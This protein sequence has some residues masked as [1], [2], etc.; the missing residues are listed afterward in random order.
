MRGGER[1]DENRIAILRY[2]E[3][4]EEASQPGHEK[5]Y[6][7]NNANVLLRIKLVINVSKSTD[8][9]CGRNVSLQ[10][11]CQNCSGT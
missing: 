9:L 10:L 7:C 5:M 4:W 11:K 3:I 2:I 1:T 8:K 6:M